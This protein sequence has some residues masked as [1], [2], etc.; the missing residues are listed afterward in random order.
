MLTRRWVGGVKRP[1]APHR[2]CTGGMW[3]VHVD[4]ANRAWGGS[5]V[6]GRAPAISRIRHARHTRASFPRLSRRWRD[7]FQS[8]PSQ[9]AAI[10]AHQKQ[11][12][13]PNHRA[14]FSSLL[15]FPFSPKASP[16]RPACIP[17][18]TRRHGPSLYR[19][20][21]RRP[22]RHT[23]NT[24]HPSHGTHGHGAAQAER[25]AASAQWTTPHGLLSK[26]RWLW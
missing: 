2:R 22:Q 4:W 1:N 14:G 25:E 17:L 26:P 3:A 15:F 7:P 12:S 6:G 10:R 13:L 21:R 24:Q 18:L 20:S 9:H 23:A 8:P 19:C 16:P 5:Q 11:P